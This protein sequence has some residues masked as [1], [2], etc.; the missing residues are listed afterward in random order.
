MLQGYS[1]LIFQCWRV[2]LVGERLESIC[3]T[4]RDGTCEKYSIS[5]EHRVVY[6]CLYKDWLASS[7]HPHVAG[8]VIFVSISPLPFRSV[9]VFPSA[10]HPLFP[11]CGH[12]L[13]GPLASILAPSNLFIICNSVGFTKC[14]PV[15]ST[16]LALPV[17]LMSSHYLKSK[18]EV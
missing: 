5:T 9:S 2:Y 14:K 10:L 8:G 18:S 3:C 7:V 15:F 4:L 11:G 6:V 1:T 12:L 13:T 17:P 16:Y